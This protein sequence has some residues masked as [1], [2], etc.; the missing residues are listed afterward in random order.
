MKL[1][2]ILKDLIK[3]K[4]MTTFNLNKEWKFIITETHSK[5][6]R[7]DLLKREILFVLQILLSKMERKN[8][9]KLKKIYNTR[10]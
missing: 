4:L 7:K 1:M 10:N 3:N 5:R 2:L 6:D 8:Y 9:L